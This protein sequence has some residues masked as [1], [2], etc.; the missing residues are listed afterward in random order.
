MR[1]VC[2]GPERG[3]REGGL[4]GGMCCSVGAVGHLCAI[5]NSVSKSEAELNMVFVIRCG[6]GGS[7]N[8]VQAVGVGARASACALAVIRQPGSPHWQ[9]WGLGGSNL[10]RS[11]G[12]RRIASS[13]RDGG[14]RAGRGVCKGRYR[15]WHLV[16]SRDLARLTTA[17]RLP[18]SREGAE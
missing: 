1:R 7:G 18:G 11:F 5:F 17:R 15:Q 12:E 9:A 3:C 16:I 10:G 8:G 2:T 6:A 4:R 13:H 14:Q